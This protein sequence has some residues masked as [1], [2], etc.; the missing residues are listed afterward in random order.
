M[1]LFIYNLVGDVITHYWYGVQC[2]K[3]GYVRNKKQKGIVASALLR[4]CDIPNSNVL[5]HPD[6]EDIAFVASTNHLGKV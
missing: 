5:L 2:K 1:D 3:I 4:T 6:G